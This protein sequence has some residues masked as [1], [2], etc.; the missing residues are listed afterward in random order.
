[1]ARADIIKDSVLSRPRK[2]LNIHPRMR[3]SAGT[4]TDNKREDQKNTKLVRQTQD[5][6]KKSN[7]ISMMT[8]FCTVVR[9]HRFVSEP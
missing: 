7:R 6:T 8:V 1:M 9:L 4:C 3:R 2:N 5:L